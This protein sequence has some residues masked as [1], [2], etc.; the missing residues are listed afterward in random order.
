M[1]KLIASD[2]DNTLLNDEL[3]VSEENKAVI[4]RFVEEGNIFALS[5][6]RS[7]YAAKVVFSQIGGDI[8]IILFNGTK[9]MFSESQ[10]VIQDLTLDDKVARDLT[11]ELIKDK[12]TFIYWKNE[13][14]YISELNDLTKYYMRKGLVG[15]HVYDPNKDELTNISKIIWLD[16]EVTVRKFRSYFAA[17]KGINIFTSEP[18]YL[19]MVPENVSKGTSLEV[20][21]KYFNV[22]IK[23]TIAVGDGENDA[24]MLKIAGVGIAPSNACLMAKESAD[25]VLDIDNNHHVIQKIVNDLI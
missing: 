17:K 13:E 11:D 19:E 8:P 24:D 23:D 5:T 9:I 20:L 25:I 10:K 21:A 18:K 6:G 1:R 15:Y 12:R 2:I 14:L 22:D 4:K 3:I 7:Y 16:E